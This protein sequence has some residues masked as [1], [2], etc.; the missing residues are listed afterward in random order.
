MSV[1]IW[2][3]GNLQMFGFDLIM[4]DPPWSFNNWS[5]LGEKKNAKSHYECM[6]L[7]EI[8]RLPVG[9]LASQ[10]CLLW[11]WCTNPMLPQGFQVLSSWG[12]KFKTAGSWIKTTKN[13]KIHFGT[14]YIL[15]SS[16]EPFLIGTIGSPKVSRNVRSSFLGQVSEHSRK[17]EEAYNAAET[18]IPNARKL[19]LFSRK[20]R[21]GWQSWGN[22]TGKFD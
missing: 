19:E 3:F 11:L 8:C 9:D 15:R 7:Q 22:E 4:A 20:N 10:N 17:P 18:L 6:S 13:N 1:S 21:E 14:G 16:N 2:P 5:K 12:F